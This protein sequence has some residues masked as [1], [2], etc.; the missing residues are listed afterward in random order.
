M[1]FKT[2]LEYSIVNQELYGGFESFS[3]TKVAV[4]KV[5]KASAFPEQGIDLVFL[6][7]PL[8]Q[9]S[10]IAIRGSA[11]ATDWCSPTEPSKI[12][13]EF[14]KEIKKDIDA[15]NEELVYPKIYGKSRQS[16]KIRSGF[17]AAYLSI[18]NT[19]HSYIQNS[20]HTCYHITG[21]S[22]GGA[23]ATLCAIDVQ[24]I[25]GKQIL[26]EAYTFGSPPV[27]NA[28]FVESYNQRV[29][30]TWRVVNRWDPVV[31]ISIPWKTYRHVGSVIKLQNRYNLSNVAW[32]LLNHHIDNYVEA[33]Q[34]KL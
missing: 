26:V 11:S 8:K 5:K 33:L 17:I 23:L 30:N 15:K 24:Y 3:T 10:V 28:A 20:N 31:G 14:V 6:E 16:I 22:L 29:L 7:N 32:N 18:R 34:K 12:K 25:F 13:Y 4:L 2:A 9:L 19:I 21:Y 27:G 1:D